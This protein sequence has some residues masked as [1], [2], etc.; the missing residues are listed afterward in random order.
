MT[1]FGLSE[2]ETTARQKVFVTAPT[3]AGWRR[4]TSIGCFDDLPSSAFHLAHAEVAAANCTPAPAVNYSPPSQAGRCTSSERG[5]PP[6]LITRVIVQASPHR[7][8]GSHAAA[9]R[10]EMSA[11]WGEE[12]AP[13]HSR[14]FEVAP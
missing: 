10:P 1:R 5:D 11:M 2:S 12:A 3:A 13:D 8:K 6:S 4:A 7:W 14:V 9:L